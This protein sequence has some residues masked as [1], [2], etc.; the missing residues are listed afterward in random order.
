MIDWWGLFAN[1]LWVVGLAAILAAFSLANYR[2]RTEQVPVRQRLQG[3]GFQIPFCSGMILFGFGL[4]FSGQ[5]WWEKA[6]GGLVALAFVV[7][8]IR[9]WK[10]R[11]T[12]LTGS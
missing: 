4:L 9:L 8:V 12:D 3:F 2:A 7:E 10:G 11:P 5:D 6:I 1:T